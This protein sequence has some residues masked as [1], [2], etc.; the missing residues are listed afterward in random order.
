MYI[1]SFNDSG[2]V[3]S[4][5]FP[6]YCI[7]P[8]PKPQLH[9]RTLSHRGNHGHYLLNYGLGTFS[10]STKATLNL[11]WTPFITL[12][13]RLRLFSLECTWYRRLC[14]PGTQ[15]SPRDSGMLSE[16]L[17]WGNSLSS[18]QFLWSLCYL[19]C[20]FYVVE[21]VLCG[22]ILQ[23]TMPS[24]I[25]HPAHVPMWRGAKVAYVLIAMCLFPVAI[26]GFWAY[27]NLVSVLT[28]VLFYR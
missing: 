25:K 28:I 8:A 20:A 23:A 21:R 7:V 3:F 1:R 10:E 2:V 14:F 12:L 22:I 9:C 4:I 24:T 17:V 5:H 26:G 19:A 16:G 15:S 18:E 6:L 27:G 13:F 11:I